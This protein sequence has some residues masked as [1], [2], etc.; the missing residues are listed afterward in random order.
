M[1]YRRVIDFLPLIVGIVAGLAYG[2]YFVRTVNKSASMADF[3][4]SFKHALIFAW[5]Q[6]MSLAVGGVVLLVG[7]VLRSRIWLM[8]SMLLLGYFGGS[9]VGARL[10]ESFFNKGA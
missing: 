5:L 9:F 6:R 7:L 2:M 10:G 3:S 4:K 1:N 8:I